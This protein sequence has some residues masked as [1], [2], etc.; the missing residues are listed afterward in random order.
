MSLTKIRSRKAEARL[1][2]FWY[3]EGELFGRDVAIKEGKSC[4]GDA[5]VYP[6]DAHTDIW[7]TI[8][9][10]IKMPAELPY[11]HFPRGQIIYNRFVRSF[12]VYTNPD[13]LNDEEFKAKIIQTYHLPEDRIIRRDILQ[14]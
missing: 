3:I 5:Y 6:P 2:S 9:D 14:D 10:E 13:L 8:R 1:A 7:N 4:S 12:T 11:D